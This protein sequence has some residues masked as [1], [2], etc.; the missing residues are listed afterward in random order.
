[1]SWYRQIKILYT[2]CSN[3]FFFILFGSI[4][5]GFLGGRADYKLYLLSLLTAFSMAYIFEKT[6]KPIVSTALSLISSEAILVFL[7]GRTS[8]IIY[9]LYICFI[10]FMA[11]INEMQ[12]VNYEIYKSKAKEAIVILLILGLIFT[13]SKLYSVQSTLKFYIIFL[14]STSILMREARNYYYSLKN[15][16]SFITNIALT[17]GIIFI[18]LDS[19]FNLV[20]ICLKFIGSII[21]KL[22]EAV[23]SLLVLIID[24]PLEA[25]VNYLRLKFS[26]KANLIDKINANQNNLQLNKDKTADLAGN[27]GLPIWL[28]TSIKLAVLMLIIYFAYKI[29]RK[30]KGRVTRNSEETLIVREKL[31]REKNPSVNFI[32]KALKSVLRLSDLREQAINVYKKFQQKT[33][34]KGI[35]RKHMT[36]RQLEN[37]TKAYIENPE[38]IDK[39]TDIYNEAKFSTHKITKDKVEAMKESLNKVKKQ[40]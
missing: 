30:Y 25:S 34:E 8:I 32:K 7:Y 26:S 5:N 38:G 39:L 4:L 3:T 2:I 12:D 13:L 27:T 37:I 24:K 18:S 36:A 28:T 31:S 33:N 20:V 9:S 14:I 35:F 23:S 16:K 6:D 22:A 11:Y 21:Y 1:M 15:S 17:L 19:V 10:L 29:L 40:L